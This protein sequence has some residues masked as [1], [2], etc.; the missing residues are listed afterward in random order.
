L[1]ALKALQSKVASVQAEKKQLEERM[2]ELADGVAKREEQLRFKYESQ[3]RTAQR[4]QL[5]REQQHSEHTR[6][7]HAIEDRLQRQ[8]H[9]TE[10][11]LQQRVAALEK[12][13]DA[14]D[15]KLRRSEQSRTSAHDDRSK[16]GRALENAEA[17]KHKLELR[18]LE[19]AQTM[20]AETSASAKRIAELEA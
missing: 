11:R 6:E 7:L 13:R 9:D 4:N 16:T 14:L 20:S 17:E 2:A 10:K 5:E 15:D 8:L 19:L 12:E 3:L 1:A 18:V